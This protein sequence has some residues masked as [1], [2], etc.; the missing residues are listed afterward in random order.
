MSQLIEKAPKNAITLFTDGAS[1]GNPGPAGVGVV[2]KYREHEKEI[3]K[4]IGKATNN[5]A[6]LE[7]IRLG[8]SEIK[9]VDIPV[10]VYT[11]SVYA[12]GVLML[13]WKAKKNL[14]IITQI[15]KRLSRFKDLKI[16]HVK[17]HAGLEGNERADR[18]ATTA[19]E[20]S[21]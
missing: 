12:H 14:E 8:L 19:I 9:K 20:N 5:Q 18:L 4:Y 13:G 21:R 16:I 6:E 7:A 2:F 15:R 11:D 17:G 10:R 1:S 3:S